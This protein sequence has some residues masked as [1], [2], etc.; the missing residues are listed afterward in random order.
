VRKWHRQALA[1]GTH[2][3]RAHPGRSRILT[4]EDLALCLEVVLQSEFQTRAAAAKH[5]HIAHVMATH[6]VSHHTIWR[7]LEQLHP[8]LGKYVLHV[9]KP[10]LKP[11]VVAARVN[12]TCKW[13][14]DAVRAD[15][16]GGCY[17]LEVRVPGS[18]NTRKVVLPP[19]HAGPSYFNTEWLSRIIWIDAKKFWVVKADYKTYGL[20]G[21]PT[22][23]I[24]EPNL[25][26]NMSIEYYAAV[27]Y[28][29]GGVYIKLCS[30]TKGPGYKP[31]QP[32]TVRSMVA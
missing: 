24:Q 14:A 9:F 25:A 2:H 19:M 5:E 31:A 1:T 6:N 10:V 20:M 18:S 15:A 7:N 8:K 32:Y 22:V 29:H 26:H 28:K 27:N 30:G 11:E 12:V 4:D 3:H 16:P 13:L 23:I 17:E 21:Q